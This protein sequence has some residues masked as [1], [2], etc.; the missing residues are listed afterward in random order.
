VSVPTIVFWGMCEMG[1]CYLLTQIAT[2]WQ[3]L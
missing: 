3:K 1:L 2:L